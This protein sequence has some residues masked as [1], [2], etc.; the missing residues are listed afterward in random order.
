LDDSDHQQSDPVA[1]VL[2]DVN[3][4]GDL[5]DLSAELEQ[6]AAEQVTDEDEDVLPPGF[7]LFQESAQAVEKIRA[8]GRNAR[9]TYVRVIPVH[10]GQKGKTIAKY[11]P[12]GLTLEGLR[13]KLPSGTYDL[14]GCTED[15]LWI[16]GKRIHLHEAAG[17]DP[18]PRANG[19]GNGG[20]GGGSAGDRILYAL[21][22]KALDQG[23]SKSSE[24]EA[25]TSAMLKGVTAMM[26]M[27]MADAKR[28]Q[29]ISEAEDRKAER[30]Q[31]QSLEMLKMVLPIVAKQ[32]NGGRPNGGAKEMGRFEDFFGALQ[33]GMSLAQNSGGSGPPKDEDENSLKS[34]LLPLADSLGPGLISVVAMMLP[35]DKARMVS[36][37]LEAHFKAREAEAVA[38]TQSDEPPTVDTTGETVGGGD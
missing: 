3:D 21:A 16:G 15:N 25:A 34:W 38:Q 31:T 27:S 1:E 12:D 26:Q 9:C 4:L 2:G 32:S 10:R 13:R 17:V 29:M 28:Q 18:A 6:L 19:A 5:G 30:G 8:G 14:Q 36:D 33:L 7:S 24:M 35:P 23:G 37:L 20:N 22:M 11:A